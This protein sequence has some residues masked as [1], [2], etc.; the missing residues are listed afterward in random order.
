ML[1]F[2]K[3][4]AGIQALVGDEY[5]SWKLAYF[6]RS[7]NF[8]R[9]QKTLLKHMHKRQI[10]MCIRKLN[11]P[12]FRTQ[13]NSHNNTATILYFKNLLSLANKIINIYL[14]SED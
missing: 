4:F 10:C 11:H 1:E 13:L 3:L 8:S 14:K 6:R 7:I 2:K 5:F 9:S 12:F